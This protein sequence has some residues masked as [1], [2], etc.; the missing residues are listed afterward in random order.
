MKLSLAWIFDHIQ[1]TCIKNIDMPNLIVQFSAK[2]AEIEDHYPVTFDIDSFTLAQVTHISA[3]SCTL[4]SSEL[5][6]EII[7]PHRKDA[8]LHNYYV[9][10]IAKKIYS[11]ATLTD[12]GSEK[13][14]LFAAMHVTEAEAKGSWK[15]KVE[16]NDYIWVIDNKAITNRPDMW[17]H[18][19][20]AREIAAVL[21]LK[22]T[23]EEQ[24]LMAKPIKHYANSASAN[25]NS[26]FALLLDQ[27]TE[28]GSICK[29]IA[30]T[31]ISSIKYTQSN[32]YIAV[33]FARVDSKP[34]DFIVDATNYVMLDI[35]QPMHAFD[36]AKIPSHKIIGRCAKAGEKIQLLDGETI[37]LA[38]DDF[39]ITDGAQ[40]IALAGV[41]GG[42]STS[43]SK[44]TTSLYIESANFDAA[45]IR[46]TATRHKKRTESSAR[47]EKSLDPNQ[48]TQALLRFLKLLETYD[49]SYEA[50]DN[51]AS[52][53][54]LAQEKVIEVT[55][56]SIVATLGIS[57]SSDT[58]QKYLMQLGFGIEIKHAT[59]DTSKI[60]YKVMVPTYRS[61]KD[62][63]IKQDIIEEV[64][65]FV[66][67]ANIP[68]LLPSRQMNPF[69]TTPITRIR[70]I[71]QQLAFGAHMNEVQTYA[72]YDEEFLKQLSYEP[73]DTLRLAQPFSLNI[74]QLVTSLVPNLFK[75]IATNGA[76]QDELRFFEFDRVWFNDVMP[77]ESKELAGIF[78]HK[79]K[80]I[81]FYVYKA[82]VQS[83]FEAL[84]V[85]VIWRKPTE[86]IGP[87]YAKH[88]TA[89]LVYE[90]QIIGTAGMI[91]SQFLHK[92]ADGEAFVFEINGDFLLN[93]KL[94]QRIFKALKK[95]QEVELDIS[96]KVPLKITIEQLERSILTAE[97][98]IHGVRLVDFFEKPEWKDQKSV[99]L[100]FVLYDDEKTL[101]KEEIDA[102]YDA[103]VTAMKLLGAE[104]R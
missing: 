4:Y 72:F 33:R 62:V 61:T 60:I 28:C 16:K 18:R 58:V 23:P 45:A 44:L 59:E 84:G 49:I 48:N 29:R 101:V 89:E 64:A 83:F 50:S 93:I 40:P 34:I 32:P 38:S 54:Q 99:T 13:E 90:N 12:A 100:R 37:E 42:M 27:S 73:T 26:P 36:A 2:V 85:E 20:F 97:K 8:A 14:G 102:I 30:G 66:G 65:R 76:K 86:A 15:E 104:I 52:L 46:K 77:V 53:G 19:G 21:N 71:K 43:V 79:K 78:Y 7:L 98:K 75:C 11:W 63:T 25:A 82:E 3:E 96:L 39:V 94:P 6:K 24:F 55:H 81:D 87:W 31:Y 56:Q 5:K 10:K 17:S 74:Q 95:Y 47:F 92:V 70:K 1:G 103:V 68:P 80:S 35:G 91:S 69:D 9:I 51:I 67:Y 57:I 22:L 41:M 88:Q